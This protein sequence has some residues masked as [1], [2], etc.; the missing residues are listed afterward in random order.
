MVRVLPIIA[1]LLWHAPMSGVVDHGQDW[2]EQAD[3]LRDAGQDAAALDYLHSAEQQ[4][5]REG[6]DC[7][8]ARFSERKARIH[9][10][11]RNPS[12]AAE[13]WSSA[14]MAAVGCP[15]LEWET[16]GW[17]FALAQARL[18]MGRRDEARWILQELSDA[19]ADPSYPIQE[20]QLAAEARGRLAQLSFEEADFAS[21]RSDYRLW[22]EALAALGFREQ[23][24]DALGW[25]ALCATLSGAGV[26]DPW[27]SLRVHPWWTDL[28]TIERAERGVEWS[29]ILLAAN[30]FD[31]FD[32]LSE[33]P[34]AKALDCP[35]GHVQPALET[36][37]A[38]MRAGRHR[39]QHV[40]QALAA[41]HQAE[42]A[43]RHIDLRSER[44]PLLGEALR[45]RAAILAATGAH[46]PAYFALHEAD[47]LSVAAERE[48]QA[49]D[50]VFDSE[51][52]L[53]AMGDARTR[54][55]TERMAQ[56]RAAASILAALLVLVVVG[57]WRYSVHLT[58]LRT[59]LRHLQRHW[60]PG[61]QHQVRELARSGTRLAEA[62]HAHA[63]PAEVKRDLA[64]FSRLA[65]LC[66]DEVRHEPVDLKSMCMT[67]ADGL[68]A[69]GH[70]EWS[71]QEEVPFRG[72]VTQ[73]Q[74]FFAVLL[75]GMGQGGCRMA[76]R[77]TSEGLE[78]T[79][80]DF[81]ER[82]WW[83][84][85]MTLFTGDG[86]ERHWSMV[87]LRCDRMGGVMNLD[88]DAA[89]AQCLK[90]ELPFYSA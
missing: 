8:V 13:A 79:F 89:G 30:R 70:L 63:L 50:G 29:R 78:V 75:S 37:W 34:W 58:R 27:D 81:T 66:A 90:V 60:L 22:S 55:E 84:G 39:S 9:T 86:E 19:G 57:A 7:W 61:R 15:E 88:C 21:A 24:M 26:S 74:D 45:M 40:A 83:R 10:D 6:E 85:A 25:S 56:W 54:L 36:R 51:P 18:D 43:A 46:G 2:L 35:P 76:M 48:A 53:A 80:D 33:W 11:W 68:K 69:E 59:R 4:F 71:L 3:S 12:H 32:A 72:D 17:K 47:S 73:L 62:A 44:D 14:L 38:L 64:E 77:S 82:G 52:W 16:R 49:R 41:S 1:L 23:A 28:S 42:L 31:A 65:A 20:R 87:R 5:R 67:L